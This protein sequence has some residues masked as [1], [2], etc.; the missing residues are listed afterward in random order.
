MTLLLQ[1][2]GKVGAWSAQLLSDAGAK[3]IGVSSAETAVFNE[4]TEGTAVCN[5]GKFKQLLAPV[6]PCFD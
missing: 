1:G 3:V 2:F 4:V 5:E 6:A